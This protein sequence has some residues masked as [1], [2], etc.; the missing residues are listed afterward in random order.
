MKYF[1]YS[2][3]TTS[4]LTLICCGQIEKKEVTEKQPPKEVPPKENDQKEMP[5]DVSFNMEKIDDNNYY[6]ITSIKLA[7]GCYVI[8]PYSLDDI[9][10]PVSLSIAE[11]KSIKTDSTLIEFP[12]SVEEYDALAE[13]QVRFVK[14]NTTYTQKL[15]L[16]NKN[17]FEVTGK[18]ELLIEPNCVPYQIDFTISNKDELI[19]VTKTKTTSLL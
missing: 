17:D 16:T 9:F 14:E 19:T 15:T 4:L 18:V 10:L 5:F 12:I 13:T 8:S 1:T 6:L 7:K 3:L 2:I 11:N